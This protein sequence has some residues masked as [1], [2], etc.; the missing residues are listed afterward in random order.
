MDDQI[1]PQFIA[2]TSDIAFPQKSGISF[3]SMGNNYGGYNIN[4]SKKVSIGTS[5]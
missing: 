5:D 1:T 4:N 2:T 3:D